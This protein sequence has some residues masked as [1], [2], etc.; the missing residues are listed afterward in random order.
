MALSNKM[1]NYSV[2]LYT[3]HLVKH[4]N[5]DHSSR[6]HNFLQWRENNHCN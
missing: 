5:I 1:K 2:N 3:S 4:L 6:G